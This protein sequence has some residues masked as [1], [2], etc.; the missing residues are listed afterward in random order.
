MNM[1]KFRKVGQPSGD[2]VSVKIAQ[3]RRAIYPLMG[4]FNN[5]RTSFGL[6]RAMVVE[7]MLRQGYVPANRSF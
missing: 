6:S 7:H 1:M 4:A 5:A 2:T 3:S